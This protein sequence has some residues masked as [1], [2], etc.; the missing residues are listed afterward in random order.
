MCTKFLIVK[1]QEQG[2][3]LH[4]KAFLVHRKLRFGRLA[5]VQKRIFLSNTRSSLNSSYTGLKEK[6]IQCCNISIL[7]NL[8][9]TSNHSSE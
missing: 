5:L 7:I 1:V 8:Y 4:K 9:S 3:I 2:S 6:C